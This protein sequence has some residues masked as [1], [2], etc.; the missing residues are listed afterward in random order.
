MYGIAGRYLGLAVLLACSVAATANAE[1]A[2]RWEGEIALPTGALQ[3]MV[4]LIPPADPARGWT[5]SID[6]PA[7]GA[8]GLALVEIAIDDRRARFSIAGVPG[9]PTFDGLLRDGELRGQFSQGAAKL[10]FRLG[11]EAV[12]PVRR[13]QDPASSVPYREEEVTYTNG[14]VTLAGTLTLPPGGGPFPA[15]VLITGSGPQNR[16][17]ELFNHRPFLVLADHLTRR[18]IAVLR[19][20]DRGV[21]GSSGDVASATSADF[22][23]DVLAGIELLARRADISA[24]RVGVIG[25]SEGGLV[26]PLAAAQSDAVAFVVMLAGPGVPGSEILAR[27]TQLMAL[28]AG[29]DPA[30]VEKQV[31]LV[32]QIVDLTTHGVDG[33]ELRQRLLG[34][35]MQQLELGGAAAR[36][37]VGDEPEKALKQQIDQLLTPWFRYF[38]AYDPRPTLERVSVP[39]LALNGE[40]DLQVDAEQNIPAVEAALEAGDNQ[41]ATTHR[42]PELNHLFQHATTGAVTEYGQIEETM[43]PEVLDLI[44][45]WIV[46]R[47]V[48]SSASAGR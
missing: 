20:D 41:D 33:P 17:E 30:T 11:R 42:L 32:R 26:G 5:G 28:A 25:H 31:G 8:F 14:D 35:A 4:D 13:P 7:Q 16:D 19:S 2:G 3:V 34:L 12:V 40:L 43:A 15:A 18:G 39:V 45:D 24:G 22:A 9:N 29:G 10:E 48:A 38:L 36:E 23:A 46:E 21:G 1:F 47:F 27:Q 37:A 44:G 6:I